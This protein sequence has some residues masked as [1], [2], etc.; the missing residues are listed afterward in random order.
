MCQV[1]VT[2]RSL[3]WT[4]LSIATAFAEMAAFLSTEWLVGEEAGA[5]AGGVTGGGIGGIVANRSTARAAA[6][7]ADILGQP[8]SPATHHHNHR[9]QHH[10]HH[11]HSH[12]NHHQLDDAAAPHHLAVSPVAA[13]VGGGASAYRPSLGVYNRCRMVRPAGPGGE[14]E[15]SCGPYAASF[16]E[17]ASG[18]WQASAVFLGAALLLLA[19]LALSSVLSLCVQSVARK[20]IFNVCGL[21]QAVAGLLLLLGLVLYAAGWGS[22]RVRD[23]CGPGAGPFRPASCSLGWAFYSALGATVGAFACAVLSAQAEVATSSD[24]VQEAIDEGK[25]LICLP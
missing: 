16:G 21:V 14:A 25:T 13:G 3:L 22:P 2:C 18:L 20:S 6:G 11:N 15:E 9:N 5:G 7:P 19:L 23:L 4:L 12:H 10:R 17:L 1:I 24:E 8:P